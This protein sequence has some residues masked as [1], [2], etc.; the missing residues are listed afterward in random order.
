MEVGQIGLGIQLVLLI[1]V[2]ENN[3][4]QGRVQIQHQ[5]KL[6]CLVLESRT[7]RKFAMKQIVYV[8]LNE[9]ERN[10]IYF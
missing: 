3:C 4:I 5:M 1:V 10:V 7:M 9:N 2:G 6:G 8:S